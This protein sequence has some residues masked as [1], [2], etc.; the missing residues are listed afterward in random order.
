MRPR[1]WTSLDN[2][3]LPRFFGCFANDEH[4]ECFV[5]DSEE[6]DF[7]GLFGPERSGSE[8]G[9]FEF[10]FLSDVCPGVSCVCEGLCSFGIAFGCTEGAVDVEV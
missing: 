10:E 7:F 8:D 5:D 9:E 4:F 1:S 6:N 2:A 3:N